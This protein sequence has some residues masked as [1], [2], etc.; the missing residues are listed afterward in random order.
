MSRKLKSVCSECGLKSRGL[1]DGRCVPCR[2]REREYEEE[3]VGF[4]WSK[5]IS[6]SF[7]DFNPFKRRDER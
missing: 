7:G 6:E 3:H 1:V 4:E 2:G 5:M